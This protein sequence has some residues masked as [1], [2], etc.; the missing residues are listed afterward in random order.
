METKFDAV[1]DPDFL[2]PPAGAFTK[3]VSVFGRNGGLTHRT[4]ISNFEAVGRMRS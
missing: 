1:A 3:P 2:L 4:P